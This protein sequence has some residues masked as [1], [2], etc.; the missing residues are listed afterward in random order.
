MWD[1]IYWT[2]F[3]LSLPFTFIV[4]AF[5]L[6]HTCPS[7]KTY[8]E[9]PTA[10]VCINLLFTFLLS[11]IWPLLIPT[12]MIIGAA[13]LVSTQYVN[14]VNSAYKVLTTKDKK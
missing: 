8:K 14:I 10:L 2:V 11:F 7:E 4:S 13:S 9:C 5:I 6:R 1:L 3:V 12:A